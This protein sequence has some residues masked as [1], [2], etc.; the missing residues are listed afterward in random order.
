MVNVNVGWPR[1]VL[2]WLILAIGTSGVLQAQ[3]PSGK[4]PYAG[5]DPPELLEAW[6]M[7]QALH[8]LSKLAPSLSKAW[9]ISS[10]KFRDP[11]VARALLDAL[12]PAPPL[13]RHYLLRRLGKLR[14]VESLGKV[15]SFAEHG[16]PW[17]VRSAAIESLGDIAHPA[18]IP[19][20]L[21]ILDD[22]E[23]LIQRRAIC[24]L[25]KIT[26]KNPAYTLTS[27][28]EELKD[29]LSDW[30]KWGAEHQQRISSCPVPLDGL[31][32]WHPFFAL[33]VIKPAPD[34]KVEVTVEENRDV[35]F[36]F[37]HPSCDILIKVWAEKSDA[38]NCNKRFEEMKAEAQAQPKSLRYKYKSVE[39]NGMKGCRVYYLDRDERGC[40]VKKVHMCVFA[41][42]HL[43]HFLLRSAPEN[44]K[45]GITTL[46]DLISK[47]V[48]KGSQGP[49]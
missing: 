32:Y 38:A 31:P 19:T 40:L 29:L 37:F 27:L 8:A 16:T 46:E 3:E 43:C 45:T 42:S 18:A 35:I 48:M 12:D 44:Y 5:A 36:D 33:G 34:W 6:E 11:K 39:R 47:A 9:I 21:N 30:K 28:P 17:W 23:P 13:V 25:H 15:I 4:H 10:W 26:G 14:C 22:A 24:A 41:D 2:T 7:V 20:L 1:L 49:K